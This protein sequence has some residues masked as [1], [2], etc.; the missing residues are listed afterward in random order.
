[1][2]EQNNNVNVVPTP[3]PA[4][5]PA[6][7][8]QDASVAQPTQSVAPSPVPAPAPA[9]APVAAPAPAPAQPVTPTPAPAPVPTVAPA[10][11]PSPVP[12]PAPAPTPVPAPAPAAVPTPTVTP[13]PAPVQPVA[14]APVPA[15]TPAPAPV[16]SPAPAP[17]QADIVPSEPINPIANNATVAPAQPVA[18]ALSPTQPQPMTPATPANGNVGFVPNGAP[19]EKKKNKGLIILVVI[20]IVA[21]LACVG[22]FVIFPMIKKASTTPKMMYEHAIKYVAKEINTKVNDSV[23][24]KTLFDLSVGIDSNMPD[25][26]S[27]SGY[28]YGINAGVDPNGKAVQAGLYMKDAKSEYSLFNYIKDGKKY[29]R[30]STDNQ[31]NFLGELTEAETNELFA[32]FNEML[33]EEDT[34][35]NEEITYLVDKVSELLISS[36]KED[37]LTREETTIKI[38]DQSVKVLNNK[39]VIDEATAEEMEKTIKDGLKA[40]AKVISTLAKMIGKE[41]DEIKEVLTYKTKEEQAKENEYTETVNDD[42]DEEPVTLIMNLYTDADLTGLVGFAL[43]D[44]KGEINVH[45]YSTEKTFEFGL[46]SKSLDEE[47]NQD[48]ENDIKAVGIVRDKVTNV[49]IT[50]N[51]KEVMTL[52]IKENTENK[53]ELSYEILGDEGAM[54]TGTFKMIIEENDKQSKAKYEFSMKAGA[55]YVNVSLNMLIDWTS[56][57]ANIN[58]G[59]A[60]QVTEADIQN[61]T[62]Q[63]MTQIYQTPVGI[64]LQTLSGSMNSGIQDYYDDYNAIQGNG[65]VVINQDQP[66]V[67]I[68]VDGENHLDN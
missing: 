33:K 66:D 36:I 35:T 28:T 11:V 51:K 27:F 17:V 43:T 50:V 32:I 26:S 63:L 7:A 38:G 67:I 64:F 25:I 22:I 6:P 34:V 65:D 56:E 12:A 59:N 45:H 40:D 20:A 61:K 46:Y 8:M 62:T 24:D 5:A 23:H 54:I 37:K 57:V 47:T 3:Q 41:E 48:V 18:P 68:D 60:V 9:P 1:M 42:E 19:I 13:A 4:P 53:L 49:S 39:Y 2:N 55:Q 10:P 14:P 52:A 15:P 29:S 58:T 44:D 31:L 21:I 16:A 30:F